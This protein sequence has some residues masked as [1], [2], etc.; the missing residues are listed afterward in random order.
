MN[1]VTKLA[2]EALGAKG[3]LVRILNLETGELEL[4]AAY[5]LGE[6]YLAKGPVSSHKIITDLCE[7]DKVVI[8]DDIRKDPRLQYPNEAMAEGIVMVLDAPLWLQNQVFGL[9]RV[10][11]SE[12]RSFSQQELDFMAAIAEQCAFA[13]DKARLIE[14]HNLEYGQLALRTEKLSALGR[15]AAGLAHE[16]NNP[17]AGILLYSTN[18]IK[19]VDPDGPLKQGLE[20]IIEETLRC[21]RII[22]EILEFSRERE[23]QK[24]LSSLNEVIEKALVLMEHEFY[25]RHISLDK[26]LDTHL[27]DLSIDPVQIRQVII[28]LLVNAIEAIGDFGRITVSSRMAL[29]RMSQVVEISDT[30]SGISPDHINKVFDPF[31]STKSK[32]TG[33]G[34]SVS[35]GI[36]RSH[37]G[38]IKVSSE[39][40]E[41]TC[42]KVELPMADPDPEH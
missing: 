17:L 4:G 25:L 11:F 33:L 39:P 15:L 18:L 28:N 3:A 21:R 36:A 32:G 14:R 1:L 22:Q 41:G 2:V 12:P 6:R 24:S 13:I 23:P 10:Y 27:P 42:F 19:K 31:F 16:I 29:D 5:G 40:K 34:L 26:R 9:I 7:Q 35:Y 38:Q 20:V 8:I 30:G 37:G